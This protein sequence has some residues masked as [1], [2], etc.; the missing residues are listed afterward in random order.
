MEARH[1]RMQECKNARNGVRPNRGVLFAC[2]FCGIIWKSPL[3]FVTL[4]RQ[5][6][7]G[8]TA[9]RDSLIAM[10]TSLIRRHISLVRRPYQPNNEGLPA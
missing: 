8:L 7:G 6:Q 4:Y 9:P 10:R 3:F 5:N 1:A 2:L